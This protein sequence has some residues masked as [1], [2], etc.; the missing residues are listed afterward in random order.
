MPIEVGCRGFVGRSLHKAFTAMGIVGT[1]R[2]RAI[3]N[4]TEKA[5]RWLWIR[6]GAPWGQASAV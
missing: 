2:S 1:T 4:I 5:S 6:R 3:K